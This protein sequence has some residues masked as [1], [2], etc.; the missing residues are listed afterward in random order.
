MGNQHAKREIVKRNPCTEDTC[1]N[2]QYTE[3]RYIKSVACTNMH[4]S[5]LING[6][7]CMCMLNVCECVYYHYQ[8]GLLYATLCHYDDV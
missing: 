2:T 4:N 3:S 8:T 5:S 7:E 1:N 6:I